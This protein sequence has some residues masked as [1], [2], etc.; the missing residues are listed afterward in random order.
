VGPVQQRRRARRVLRLH[1]ATLG[2]HGLRP[3]RERGAEP[4][5][6]GRLPNDHLLG[7]GGPA[8]GRS[9]HQ[10]RERPALHAGAVLRAARPCHAGDEVPERIRDQSTADRRQLQRE[11]RQGQARLDP[12][13]QPLR[14]GADLEDPDALPAPAGDAALGRRRGRADRQRSLGQGRARQ[15][16]SDLHLGQRL[17]AGTAPPAPGQVRAVRALHPGPAADQGAGNP[18][19]GPAPG[20]RLERRHHRDHPEDRERRAGAPAGR[21]LPAPLRAG[22]EPQVDPADPAGDRPARRDGRAGNAGERRQQEGPLRHLREEPRPRPDGPA[23]TRDHRPP[24]P[25]D[26]HQPLRAGQ[27]LEREPRDVRPR[28]RQARA[29]VGLQEPALLPGA[30]VPAQE[31]RQAQRLHRR[32]LQPRPRQTA[33]SPGQEEEAQ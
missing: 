21:S 6:A 26:P 17:H 23:R 25:G 24:V 13:D 31:A 3:G 32:I 1:Q 7:P 5:P 4:V 30:Q 28:G 33:E 14:A 22:P 8:D 15:H 9:L 20:R 10:S 12:G 27:V 18:R 29:Q 16:L 2:V 11:E 19:R